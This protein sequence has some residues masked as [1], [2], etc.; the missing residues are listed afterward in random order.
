MVQS[1]GL[2][3]T[4]CEVRSFRSGM[5]THISQVSVTRRDIGLEYTPPYL[6]ASV[7]ALSLLLPPHLLSNRL[8]PSASQR[9]NRTRRT[10]LDTYRLK[11]LSKF[12]KSIFLG[13]GG[14]SGLLAEEEGTGS[15]TSASSSSTDWEMGWYSERLGIVQEVEWLR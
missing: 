10:V 13:A 7:R 2:C 11:A 5:T 12:L 4:V 8:C 3:R 14:L 6:L 1:L 15:V 9:R